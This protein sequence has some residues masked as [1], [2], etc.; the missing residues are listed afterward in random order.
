MK[1]TLAALALLPGCTAL[2]TAQGGWVSPTSDRP[3][4]E[5]VA[6][7]LRMDFFDHSKTLSPGGGFALRGKLA[8]ELFQVS[9]AE[10]AFVLYGPRAPMR[11]FV[12]GGIN[13]FQFESVD[14]GFGFGMFSPYAEAGLIFAIFPEGGLGD[15][16]LFTVSAA[17][18]YDLRFTDQENQ[19]YFLV[20]FG[21]G[22]S[23]TM[24]PLR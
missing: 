22:G 8:D 1:T 19:G 4:H 11:P 23:I 21:I 7:D 18:E 16:W 9:I 17:A 3:G 24:Q 5:G 6:V 10:E 15:D 12:R 13:V 14:G 2:M 20:L